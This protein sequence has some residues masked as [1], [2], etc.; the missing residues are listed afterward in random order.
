MQISRWSIFGSFAFTCQALREKVWFPVFASLWISTVITWLPCWMVRVRE[1]SVI[2][3]ITEPRMCPQVKTT[4][5][6][7]PKNE[8]KARESGKSARLLLSPNRRSCKVEFGMFL[9]EHRAK[10]WWYQVF[11][12]WSRYAGLR[13]CFPE[14]WPYSNPAVVRAARSHWRW[15]S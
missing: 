6:L 5:R 4:L 12:Y 3:R 14:R 1:W 9:S 11:G 7:R 13:W 15:V 10:W 8:V 2:P